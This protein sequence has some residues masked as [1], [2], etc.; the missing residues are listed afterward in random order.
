LGGP[1]TL[2]PSTKTHLAQH[3]ID[4]GDA[5]RFRAHGAAAVGRTDIGGRADQLDCRLGRHGTM[6]TAPRLTDA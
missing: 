1:G 2:P 4:A 6:I 3:E 5:Q